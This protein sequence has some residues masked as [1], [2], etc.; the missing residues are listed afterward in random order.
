MGKWREPA[1]PPPPV[2]WSLKPAAGVEG[3]KDVLTGVC[4]SFD[5]STCR[6]TNLL[7]FATSVVWVRERAAELGRYEAGRCNNLLGKWADEALADMA[8]LVAGMGEVT[9]LSLWYYLQPTKAKLDDVI[10]TLKASTGRRG[11][12][13]SNACS[14]P[15]VRSEVCKMVGAFL[16]TGSTSHD[17][18]SEFFLREG[19]KGQWDGQFVLVEE[20]VPDWLGVDAETVTTVGQHVRVLGGHEVGLVPDD[21]GKRRKFIRDLEEEVSEDTAL[22]VALL[23][24]ATFSNDKKK[25]SAHG[26]SLRSSLHSSLVARWASRSSSCSGPRS[27]TS[28]RASESSSYSWTGTSSQTSPASLGRRWRSPRLRSTSPASDPSSPCQGHLT[29]S[30]PPSSASPSWASSRPSTTGRPPSPARTTASRAG[31]G[32]SLP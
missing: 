2:P 10:A 29:R 14:L 28:S 18:R 4:S 30:Q 22:L 24:S 25:T 31:T 1:S 7:D 5:S 12:E 20:N 32:S 27:T 23:D 8:A 17:K 6:S 13:L 26:D 15:A 16:R 21:K 19:K 11:G 9:E 3:I